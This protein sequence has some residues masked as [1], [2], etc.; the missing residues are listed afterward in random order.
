MASRHYFLVTFMHVLL[1]WLALP[2]VLL[3][4]LSV[5][6]HAPRFAA[7][8]SAKSKRVPG[9]Q[10]VRLIG[11]GDSVIEGVGARTQEGALVGQ[12]AILI[13]ES[14][15][16]GVVW[17]CIGS[18]GATSRRVAHTLLPKLPPDPV[19]FI[20]VSV[21]VNDITSM[22]TL[23]QWRRSLYFIV[24]ALHKHSPDAI[25]AVAGIPPLEEFPLLPQ[26]LRTVLGVRGKSYDKVAREVVASFP[27]TVHVSLRLPTM[28]EN[29]AADGF[30]PSES[31]YTELAKALAS[32]M[33]ER[34]RGKLR[35]D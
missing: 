3:Q 23:R 35:D 20:V 1:Y 15:G 10:L 26:P 2:F 25:V 14:L 34:S 33:L 7:P 13:A 17:E 30:H 18:I 11:I 16:V 32:A 19:N 9:D 5:R 28:N 29:F 8:R 24:A 31:S 27:N 21:G 4:A 12:T 6:R 22:A